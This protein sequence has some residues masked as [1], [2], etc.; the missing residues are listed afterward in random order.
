MAHGSPG[1]K[2][3]GSKQADFYRNSLLLP[4]CKMGN[5]L[6]A[7]LE[8]VRLRTEEAPASVMPLLLQI[9]SLIAARLPGYLL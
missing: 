4:C 8:N 2:F 1:L 9:G 5:R 6:S 3:A 7:K